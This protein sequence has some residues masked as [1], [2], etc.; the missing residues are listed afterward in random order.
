MKVELLESESIL[1]EQTTSLGSK[2]KLE[3][4]KKRSSG[5]VIKL[6]PR[7]LEIIRF[8]SEM[9]FAP[10]DMIF[11][12]FF[13]RTVFGETAVSLAWTRRR[14]SQLERAGFI[15]GL[16]SFSERTR[17]Y[18]GKMKG[19]Y[20]LKQVY[21]E[22]ELVKPIEGFDQRTFRHDLMV[23]EFRVWCEENLGIRSWYSEK[24]IK[25]AS[26][27]S[28][29]FGSEYI[30]DGIYELSSTGERLAFE[31]ELSVKAKSRYQDKIRKYIQIMRDKE[32]SPIG[33]VHFVCEEESVIKRLE[34]ETRLY[35][36]LFI[37]E[38][39]GKYPIGKTK[40]NF[41]KQGIKQNV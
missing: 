36:E 18:R 9:K 29:W 1:L 7:D 25:S 13:R 30:P 8:V 35:P 11:A 3:T 10:L 40:N 2:H 16:Y 24:L 34:L 15:E 37:I 23:S 27:M 28:A 32:K 12:K 33:R 14:L 4:K 22:S 21:P 31:L 19:Y 26:G 17:L 39:L 5:L 6:F 38:P 41:L 20:A